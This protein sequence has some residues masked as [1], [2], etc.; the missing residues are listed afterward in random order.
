MRAA[1]SHYDAVLNTVTHPSA[2]DSSSIRKFKAG[3]FSFSATKL[4]QT[5]F[6]YIGLFLLTVTFI[7]SS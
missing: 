5:K 2:E 1:A 3:L 4:T 7:F 6:V